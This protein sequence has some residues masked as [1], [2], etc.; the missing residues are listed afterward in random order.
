VAVRCLGGVVQ[1][2]AVM[3]VAV[4]GC[5]LAL[6]DAGVAAAPRLLISAAVGALV[7]VV[8]CRWRVPEVARELRAMA[9]R[10]S[11]PVP[12]PEPAAP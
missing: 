9:R 6:V 4:L 10:M 11:T 5:R 12:G 8:L 3:A 2:A 1:A 7:F